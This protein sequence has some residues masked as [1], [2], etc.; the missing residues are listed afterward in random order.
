M[1]NQNWLFVEARA[2]AICERQGIADYDTMR[3]IALSIAHQSFMQEIQP[4]L[5]IKARPYSYTMPKITLF[6]D[7]RSEVVYEFSADA[8]ALFKLCDDQIAKSAKA[9]GTTPL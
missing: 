4:F 8:Q 6:P 3:A 2:R 5:A 1:D 7:G 9:W